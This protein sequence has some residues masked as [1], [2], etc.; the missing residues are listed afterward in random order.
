MEPARHRGALGTPMGP[1]ARWSHG[2]SNALCLM[3]KEIEM[4]EFVTRRR[5][6]TPRALVATGGIGCARRAWATQI[7]N[8]KRVGQNQK[9]IK[10]R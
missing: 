9:D 8:H 6:G 4:G 10:N 5:T 3:Q 1:G 7:R 2:S